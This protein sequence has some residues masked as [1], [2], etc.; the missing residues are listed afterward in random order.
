MKAGDHA[1]HMWQQN[2]VVETSE[3]RLCYAEATRD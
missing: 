1:T 3:Y 2:Y